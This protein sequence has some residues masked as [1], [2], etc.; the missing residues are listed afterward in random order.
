MEEKQN[1]QTN[2]STKPDTHSQTAF[3]RYR[4]ILFV[5]LAFLALGLTAVSLYANEPCQTNESG[6][7]QESEIAARSEEQSVPEIELSLN[8]ES[9]TE[10]PFLHGWVINSRGYT[11]L[12]GNLGVEQFNYSD[13]TFDRFLNAAVGISAQVP[14]GTSVFCMPIP[15]TIGFLYSEIPDEIKKSDDFFNSSQKTFLD[16]VED[17]LPKRVSFVPLYDAFCDALQNDEELFFRTDRNWTAD[18]AFLAYKAFCKAAGNPATSKDI[19]QKCSYPGF[20]GSFYKATGASSL[21]SY[22]E[23][24]SYYC[25]EDTDACEV[26]LY[27]GQ[28]VFKSY[29][30]TGNGFLDPCDAYLSYLGTEGAY[31]KIK[32]PCLTEQ[33]LLIIGDESC[34]AMIPFLIQNYSE[35]HYVNPLRYRGDLL[36]I[37]T[38]NKFKDILIASYLTN[39][40]KGDFPV[41]LET[42]AGVKNG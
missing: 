23:V 15:T 10:E 9:A 42:I 19:Y 22:P 28:N 29:R 5:V 39:A 4:I 14:D 34:A 37:F 24:F 35:I 25:N 31:F 3:N 21:E 36:D 30:L 32:S 33:K 17:R 40:V 12:Y 16:T 8:A 13:Q 11:Y 6:L 2:E 18:A 41:F 7:S 38:D 1:N 26:T 27:E 20:L